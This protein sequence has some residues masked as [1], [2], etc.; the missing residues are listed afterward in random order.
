MEEG[1]V[2]E[3]LSFVANGIVK[4]QAILL[5]KAVATKKKKIISLSQIYTENGVNIPI[6]LTNIY[7]ETFLVHKISVSVQEVMLK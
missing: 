2:R 4:H 5:G 6:K 3:L 1:G 7:I